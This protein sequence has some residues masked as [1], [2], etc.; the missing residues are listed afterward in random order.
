[1]IRIRAIIIK[2]LWERMIV[3]IVALF[4]HAY[5]LVMIY[6][7]LTEEKQHYMKGFVV[8]IIGGTKYIVEHLLYIMNI[9]P[10]LLCTMLVLYSICSYSRNTNL[11]NLKFALVAYEID[12]AINM[13]LAGVGG[14]VA[15]IIQTRNQDIRYMVMD[16]RYIVLAIGR[17][18]I[19]FLLYKYKERIAQI[20]HMRGLYIAVIAA[21]ILLILEQVLRVVH[22]TEQWNDMFI[23]LACTYLAALFTILWLLDHYKMAK[24]QKMYADDNRQMS[25][26]LH[27]SKEILPMIAN[28]VSNMDGTQDER[29][30]EKLEAVCHDY[31]K[32]LGGTEMS[33]ELF[34][35]TGIDLVDLL[36]R[37][38]IIECGDQDIE[39]EVFVSEQIDEDMKRLDI[40]DGEIT[41]LLGDLLRNA[42]HAVKDLSNKMI[43]LLI[44]HDENGCVLIRIYDSGVP[45]PDQILERFGERGNTT[46]GTGNGIADMMETVNRVHASIE[47]NMEMDPGD[48]FTKE[49]S[50]CFDGNDDFHVVKKSEK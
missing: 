49:L 19:I 9:A 42:I 31:G 27:R 30:R 17:M 1:M 22:T 34:E 25:Q 40:G 13:V 36:L 20:R 37:T 39:M 29:M 33:A 7:L 24:L 2:K 18:M 6:E 12:Y 16:T 44:A 45:F 48:V 14:F 5:M 3:K 50:I 4:I 21:I 41:R 38:K 47:I 11:T 23:A 43:L 32:E 8:L 10:L 15:T 28:Y 26:K 35:T 46:W